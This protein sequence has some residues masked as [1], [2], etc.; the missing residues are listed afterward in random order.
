MYKAINNIR[1][2][3]GF[4]LIELLIVVAII[5]ILAAIAIPAY[6][7]AQEKAR[8]SNLFRASK[9]CEADVQHW[10]NSAIKGAL[11]GTAPANLTEV[12][13][14]WSGAV[15]LNLDMTNNGL[16]NAG[17]FA[18]AADGVA[19]QYVTARSGGGGMSGAEQSP[20]AGMS[21]C[22]GASGI[23]FWFSP[24]IAADLPGEF[25][26]VTL[27]SQMP[28]IGAISG[29][30]IRVIGTSNGPGGNASGDKELMTSTLVTA[31]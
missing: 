29:N 7:G 30:S 3:K 14:D 25:C 27:S 13:S 18:D 24:D 28:P 9:S 12:D 2:Q 19:F 20:W 1:E 10:L 26:K 21:Q 6:I 5:G 17:G 11:A 22:V 23:L 4:T 15:K 8:K 31:E 16:Y